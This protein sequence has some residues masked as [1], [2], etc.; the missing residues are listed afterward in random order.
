MV[1]KLEELMGSFGRW[2]TWIFCIIFCINIVGMWQNFS[3]SF[4]A[5]NVGFHCVNSTDRCFFGNSSLPCTQWE[6]D[7]SFYPETI[8]SKWDLVCDREWLISMV[9]SSY[10]AGFLVSTILFGQISDWI[11]RFPVL[12]I[13]YSITMVSMFLS[14]L[15]TSYVMFAALRF[16]QAL[17]RIGLTTTGYVLLMEVV[18]EEHRTNVGIYIQFGWSIGFVTL[19]V[20]AYFLRNW[21]SLQLAIFLS[22]IPLVGAYKILPESPRWLMMQGKAEKLEKLLQKAAK[23]NKMEYKKMNLDLLPKH[24]KESPKSVLDLFKAPHL[25]VRTL[26]M[27]YLWMVNAFMY[28]GLSYNTND[29]AGDPYINFL[30][31][32]A[33]E[34]PSYMLL[35][36]AVKRLGRRPTLVGFML[37]AGIACGAIAVSPNSLPWLATSLA[38]IGKFCITASF[39]LLYLYTGELFPTV[40]RNVAIGSSSMWGR[41]GSIIA[42]FVKELGQATHAWL[43]NVVYGLLAIS[44]GLLA[45]LLPETK[46]KKMPDTLEEAAE[47]EVKP[48]E[49]VPLRQNSLK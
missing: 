14:L 26:C 48:D 46:D 32:G 1:K 24:T 37:A 39:G 34:I 2:Q 30:V 19:P 11:G 27:V 15:S 35:I 29:L 6:Y 36:W 25:R 21:I 44:S 22:F 4:L 17:G 18:G 41:I 42:P 40:V 12:V 47:K 43:P 20:I 28:Y 31:S 9:K 13:C 3:I 10:M 33:L 5:P 16:F 49:L 45:L 8:V 38:M 7:T 23:M